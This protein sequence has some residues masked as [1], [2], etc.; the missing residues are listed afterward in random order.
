MEKEQEKLTLQA[1]KILWCLYEAVKKGE[2]I[3][4]EKRIIE[5]GLKQYVSSVISYSLSE[6]DI[7][8]A[9]D[10][11]Q[12]ELTTTDELDIKERR[13]DFRRGIDW[14]LE[15]L[16][17]SVKQE[18]KETAAKIECKHYCKGKEELVEVIKKQIDHLGMATADYF[19][20]YGESSPPKLREALESIKLTEE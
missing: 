7:K 12:G 4:V 2:Q 8:W 1:N 6:G 16:S 5:N 17:L 15:R 10:D 18:V 13:R 14:A 19:D 3:E 11:F 9:L 20:K